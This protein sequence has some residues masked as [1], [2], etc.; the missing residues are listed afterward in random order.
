MTRGSCEG[1]QV[2]SGTV[3]TIEYEVFDVDGECVAVSE[4]EGVRVVFGHGQL[5]PR[6]EQALEGSMAGDQRTVE[7]SPQEAYGEWDSQAVLSVDPSEFP[8]GTAAG[9][10]FEAESPEGVVLLFRVLDV[11]PEAVLLDTNHPLAGQ[12]V[13]FSLRVRSVRP[14]SEEEMEAATTNALAPFGEHQS[15][16]QPSRNIVPPGRLLCGGKRR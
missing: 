10:E 16:P 14:A 6:L 3:V 5:L 11:M 12:R 15:S 9:D 8:V 1:F 7:L 2:G 13:R 4:S